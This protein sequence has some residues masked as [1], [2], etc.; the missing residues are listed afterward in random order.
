MHWPTTNGE[1]CTGDGIKSGEAIRAK[2]ID[3]D[4]VQDFFSRR[5]GPHLGRNG[6]RSANKLG[7]R[8]YVMGKRP[9]T[10]GERC[11][12]DGVKMGEAISEKSIDPQGVLATGGVG[13]HFSQPS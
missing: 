10:N 11:T 12:G 8:D 5:W 2:S 9:T 4:W 7:R 6:K 3:I 13:A 1:R